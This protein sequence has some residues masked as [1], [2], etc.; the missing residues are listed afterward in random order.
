[1]KIL[2]QDVSKADLILF[3]CPIIQGD[4]PMFCAVAAIE[5]QIKLL[6]SIGCNHGDNWLFRPCTTWGTTLEGNQATVELFR[7]VADWVT[8]AL[9]QK[10]TFKDI[11]RRAAMTR[12][13]NSGEMSI[14]D[15]AKYFGVSRTTVEKY[16]RLAKTAPL[17]AAGILSGVKEDA[18][19]KEEEGEEVVVKRKPLVVKH[20]RAAKRVKHEK[21]GV[22]V[23]NIKN[24]PFKCT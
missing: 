8:S 4:H 6:Q 13:V 19:L 22:K 14:A 16:H 11:G 20:T 10:R 12:L 3:K 17:K 1:M 7:G 24:T 5:R 15:I 2:I 18:Q 23:E 9:D 21:Q